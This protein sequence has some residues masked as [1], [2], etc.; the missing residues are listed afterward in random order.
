MD[1][2]AQTPFFEYFVICSG[3]SDRQIKALV[4][5]STEAVK[6]RHDLSPRAI[7]G[8]PETGWVLVDFGD[9]IV[10]AFSGEKRAYYDLE[11]L[12]SEGKVVV[13]IK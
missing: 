11:A 4:E 9:V 3:N 6:K 7:E 13:R 12:W 2:R 5:A 1:L 10:H 8:R